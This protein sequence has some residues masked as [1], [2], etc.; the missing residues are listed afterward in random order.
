M[1]TPNKPALRN[2]NGD[3]QMFRV[4]LS[5]VLVLGGTAQAATVTRVIDGDTVATTAGRVRVACID[6]PESNQGSAGAKSTVALQR[7]LPNG[8]TVSLRQQGKD[9]YGRLVAEVY[10]GT[11][12]VGLALVDQGEAFVYWQYTAGCDRSLYGASERRARAN[13]LG[14]WKEEGGIQ[15]PW[16]YRRSK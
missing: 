5:A 10:R 16:D 12:N 14:I 8:T 13:R 11:T 2:H 7:L 3:L 4:L 6:A 9:R 15:R 1:S